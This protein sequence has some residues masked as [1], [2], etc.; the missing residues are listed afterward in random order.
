MSYSRYGSS[1]EHQPVTWWRGHPVYAAHLIVIAYVASMLVTTV[2][3]LARLGSVLDG[4]AFSSAAVW[5]GE[6]WRVLTYGLVN[7]P[8]IPFAVDLLMIVWFGRE[9]ERFLGRRVFLQLYTGI[10]VIKPLLFTAL[11]GWQPA[12]FAG[13]VGA[14]ALFIAFAT[15]FPNAPLLFNILAKWA[16]LALVGILALSALAAHQW[17][18]LAELLATCGFAFV[19]VRYQQGHFTLPRIR[20]VRRQPTPKVLPDER[21]RRKVAAAAPPP[22]ATMAEVDALLDKIAKSGIHSLTAAE[23]ARLDAAR[24]DLLK[25]DANRR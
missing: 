19:F 14:F 23:R 2:M 3:L 6:V 18:Q 12:S 15:L 9:V 17:V 24:T 10:Y 1:E 20:F 5:R 13:E 8:S 7:A 16:A 22:G 11:Q 4:L 25:R 21:P